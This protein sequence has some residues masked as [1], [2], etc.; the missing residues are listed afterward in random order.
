[1]AKP[2]YLDGFFNA[3]YADL[4]YTSLPC[5]TNNGNIWVQWTIEESHLS[6]SYDLA[7]EPLWKTLA[8]IKLEYVL[9]PTLE[10][11]E[12]LAPSQRETAEDILASALFTC[13]LLSRDYSARPDV[14]Y[15][16]LALGLRLAT[17]MRDVFSEC[18]GWSN[19][20]HD[21]VLNEGAIPCAEPESETNQLTLS[22]RKTFF[23]YGSR[24]S[25]FLGSAHQLLS[26]ESENLMA[27]L[28]SDDI[29]KHNRR[30]TSLWIIQRSL[31]V[32]M[33]FL[34][35]EKDTL[36]LHSRFS[37]SVGESTAIISQRID[38]AHKEAMKVRGYS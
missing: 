22:N 10:M 30:I 25:S 32:E 9:R 26:I 12:Q 17:E 29:E 38:H 5:K 3:A 20:P 35:K 7:L 11:L 4:L 31:D 16:N 27:G 19:W 14:L 1:M 21:L 2:I 33:V 18:F 34:K 37:T 28:L 23:R 36:A 8:C 15:L 13:A 24:R 6:I